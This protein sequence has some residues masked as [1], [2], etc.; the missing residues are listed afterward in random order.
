LPEQRI[1]LPEIACMDLKRGCLEFIPEKRQ[2]KQAGLLT[3]DY[4]GHIAALPR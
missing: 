1:C 3:T 4:V 2:I